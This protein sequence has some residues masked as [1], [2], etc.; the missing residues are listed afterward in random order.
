MTPSQLGLRCERKGRLGSLESASGQPITP[1][2]LATLEE[3]AKAK[4]VKTVF[5]EPQLPDDVVRPFAED[6]KLNIGHLDPVGGVEGRMTYIDL[7][8][9]NAKSVADAL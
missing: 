7:M 1:Q 5:V 6:L 9:W 4:G 2:E 8:R 3:A